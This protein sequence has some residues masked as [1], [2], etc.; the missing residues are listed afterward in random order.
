MP[1]SL[2]HRTGPRAEIASAIAGL[3]LWL[4]SWPMAAQAV[5]PGPAAKNPPTP[6]DET[7]D[8]P[9]GLWELLDVIVVKDEHGD[10]VPFSGLSYQALDHLL[11]IADRVERPQPPL[12]TVTS[13]DVT[14]SVNSTVAELRVGLR[15]QAKSDQWTRVDLPFPDGFVVDAV[16]YLGKGEFEFDRDPVT[17]SFVAW[18]RG[19][20]EETHELI[21]PFRVPVTRQGDNFR[22]DLLFPSS[23]NTSL[24]L[25]WP[26]TSGELTASPTAGL[27]TTTRVNEGT[28]GQLRGWKD[29]FWLQWGTQP[30]AS[31]ESVDSPPLVAESNIVAS[32]E[33]PGRVTCQAEIS[34]SIAPMAKLSDVEIVLPPHARVVGGTVSDGAGVELQTIA[35]GAETA[36]KDNPPVVRLVFAQPVVNSVRIRLQTRTD[37]P[38]EADVVEGGL[39]VA[40]FRVSGAVRQTGSIQLNWDRPWELRWNP[41]GPI[42]RTWTTTAESRSRDTQE[43]GIRFDFVQQPCELRVQVV[44]PQ[45]LLRVD[46][47]YTLKFEEGSVSL[48]TRLA[49][50]LTGT[51]PDE[52]VV[53]VGDWKILSLEPRQPIA[54][55]TH[56]SWE[57]KNGILHVPL[58]QLGASAAND[59][60]LKIHAYRPWEAEP[61]QSIELDL[62][63]AEAEVLTSPRCEIYSHEKIQLTLDRAITGSMVADSPDPVDVADPGFRLEGRYRLPINSPL[64][65]LRFDV[66]VLQRFLHAGVRSQLTFDSQSVVVQQSFDYWVQHEATRQLDWS[67]PRDVVERELPDNESG[68]TVNGQSVIRTPWSGKVDLPTQ[69]GD[70]SRLLVG[71]NLPRPQKGRFQV[72]VRYRLPI[73]PSAVHHIPLITPVVDRSDGNTATVRHSYE[74]R[75]K[76]L[77]GSPWQISV[78]N[79]TQEKDSVPGFEIATVSPVNEVGL[80]LRKVP[81]SERLHVHVP[82]FWLQTWSTGQERRD[83]AVFK[84]RTMAPTVSVQL[85]KSTSEL[86]VVLDGKSVPADFQQGNGT[87]VI[88]LPTAVAASELHTLEIAYRL[89]H[90]PWPELLTVDI[91][92][93]DNSMTDVSMWSLVLPSHDILWAGTDLLTTE[94]RWQWNGFYWT[95][96]STSSQTDIERR[97]SASRQAPPPSAAQEY[98]FSTI[99]D[100]QP[101]TVRTIPRFVLASTLSGLIFGFGLLWVYVRTIRHPLTLVIVASLLIPWIVASPSQ[102]LLLGQFAG[103]GVLLTILGCALSRILQGPSTPVTTASMSIPVSG[104]GSSRVPNPIPSTATIKP[105]SAGSSVPTI[106]Q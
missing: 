11:R 43:T 68:I 2:P 64:K 21:I 4:G 101:L 31:Q 105:A 23:V 98:T 44:Q 56:R 95:R 96:P 74:W 53:N 50:R 69:P 51:P 20:A 5:E 49:Y 9:R 42:R 46:P 100:L 13:V 19:A 38:E 59:F 91:P 61:A 79:N 78:D 82:Q 77:D 36:G 106:V 41:T 22:L 29:R 84:L 40:G 35:A 12:A 1:Q 72:S 8:A 85:P 75:V 94:A 80:D 34:L 39:D 81:A 45:S 32:V 55:Q 99:G 30:G 58:W 47:S 33:G 60:E 86:R 6:A 76:L 48:T 73:Q 62:P 54:E 17:R 70:R 57:L 7:S 93:L 103:P 71:V 63:R 10:L 67:V 16:E 15:V 104:I 65:K 97:L 26:E 92:K 66:R 25:L 27:L 102:A 87:C 88:N 3:I 37:R 83:R 24:S 28:Q 90:S 18:F 14:G 52:L 89:P